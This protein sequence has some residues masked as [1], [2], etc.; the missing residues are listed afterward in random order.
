MRILTEN[1]QIHKHEKRKPHRH[2]ERDR[3]SF[4]SFIIDSNVP[5]AVHCFFFIVAEVRSNFQYTFKVLVMPNFS[6][7]F[8]DFKY[9]IHYIYGWCSYLYGNVSI[10]NWNHCVEKLFRFKSVS[11]FTLNVELFCIGHFVVDILCEIAHT[12][13]SLL[14]CNSFLWVSLFSLTLFTLFWIL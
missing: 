14:I 9:Y 10:E 4:I 8:N 12:A 1:T 11:M 13:R 5:T 6:I 7:K 3:D 2:K